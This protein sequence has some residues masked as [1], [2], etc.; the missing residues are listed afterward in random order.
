MGV[1]RCPNRALPVLDLG[2]DQRA[3]DRN[4]EF[5]ADMLRHTRVVAAEDLDLTPTP[6]VPSAARLRH[7]LEPAHPAPHVVIP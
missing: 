4:A 1:I 6:L 3:V 7:D 2:A 5:A